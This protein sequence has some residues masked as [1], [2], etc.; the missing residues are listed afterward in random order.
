LGLLGKPFSLFVRFG[1]RILYTTQLP[2]FQTNESLARVMN[3]H[4]E[5]EL[6]AKSLG[7]IV[8]V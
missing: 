1:G 8:A 5:I 7:A 3:L 4:M 2:N 6:G